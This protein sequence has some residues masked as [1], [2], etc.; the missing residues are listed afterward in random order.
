MRRCFATLSV[1]V[2][3]L[4]IST[5]SASAAKP[6]PPPPP[7]LNAGLAIMNTASSCTGTLT[8]TFNGGKGKKAS[9]ITRVTWS[10]DASST[11]TLGFADGGLTL[12]APVTSGTFTVGFT[13]TA[14]TGQADVSAS[15]PG[16]VA[17]TT[18][19]TVTCTSPQPDL[20]VSA[21]T[22]DPNSWAY[23]ATVKNIGGATADLTNVAVQG[24]YTASTDTTTFPPLGGIPQLSGNDPAGGSLIP[25]QLA[26]TL[27][28][29]ATV[30]VPLGGV[31]P[32]LAGDNQL[33]VGVDVDHALAESNENNNVSVVPRL[34]PPLP[35]LT[36]TAVTQD[37]SSF[38][39]TVTVKNIGTGT[40]T[41]GNMPV[42]GYYTASTDTTTFPPTGEP[43]GV[44]SIPPSTT[45]APGDSVNVT[46][47]NATGPVN[48]ANNQLM[49]GVNLHTDTPILESDVT[50]NVFVVAYVPPT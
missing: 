46:I 16:F 44:A 24:Y 17:Q 33:M 13:L 22:Q 21:I 32:T 10:A 20:I 28:P 5:T 15:G 43:A 7:G 19:N 48:G 35:D 31:G 23:S 36:I 12:A 4:A 42:L 45:L 27:A 9:A 26:T 50:N 30:D 14:G 41:V 34:T 29:N 47:T 18:S 2:A 40:G 49:V 8:V 25:P 1:V 11:G 37:P 38:N 3:I 6:L 39:F